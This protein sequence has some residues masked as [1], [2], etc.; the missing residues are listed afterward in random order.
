MRYQAFDSHL[1][2]KMEQSNKNVVLVFP[3]SIVE[4]DMYIT[5]SNE[6]ARWEQLHENE[7]KIKRKL[8]EWSHEIKPREA[9]RW[10]ENVQDLSKI[11]IM[12]VSKSKLPIKIQSKNLPA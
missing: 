11:G 12:V 6:K 9:D 4:I 10:R 7:I 1:V 2:C 8:H 3:I 5:Q